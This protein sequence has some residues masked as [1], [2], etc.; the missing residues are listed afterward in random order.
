MSKFHLLKIDSIEHVDSDGSI[1]WSNKDVLN[2]LHLNGELFLL[3]LAFNTASEIEVPSSYY[4]GLDARDTIDIE[5]ELTE[6][7]NEPTTNG[8]TRQAVSSLNGFDVELNGNNF[9]AV[10]GV[11][12]FSASGGTWGPVT[13]LFLSTSS[14]SSGYLISSVELGSSRTLL[15]GQSIT[16]RFSLGLQNS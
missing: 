11:V 12:T 1:L 7:T 5:D 16:M 6:I 4:L 10:S 14:T 13:N 9:R 15:D 3:S 8:Y 2:V